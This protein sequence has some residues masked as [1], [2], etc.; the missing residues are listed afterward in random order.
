MVP[1]TGATSDTGPC[2][3]EVA[4]TNVDKVREYLLDLQGRITTACAQ[5]DGAGFI[6]DKWS[7][8]K[9]E[10]LQ[11]DGITAI[12]EGGGVFERAGC[13]FSHVVGPRL[14]PSATQNR[15]ELAGAPFEAMGVSLVFH[16]R[17]P[18]VPT[19]HMNVRMISR[20]APERRRAGVLVRRR[21]G[22]DALLRLRAGCGAFPQRVQESAGALRR[23]Q[24]PA[25][26]DL[27]RRLFLLEASRR[28]TRHRRHLLRRLCRRRL[29]RT[30]SR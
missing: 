16:P 21:D 1:S 10:P 23:R 13:G 14:P 20:G 9:G 18:Y 4:M 8:G 6:R 7:K 15:P 26:Q 30:A 27:V 3:T 5:V 28:T 22:P 19:V 17:N 11:G 25:L 24:I 29:R 12:L 2:A